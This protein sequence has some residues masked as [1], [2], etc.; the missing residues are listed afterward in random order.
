MEKVCYLGDG[1]GDGVGD[2][3]VVG[4]HGVSFEI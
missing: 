4:V 1:V 2:G 3:A